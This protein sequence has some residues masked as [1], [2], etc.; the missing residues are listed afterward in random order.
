MLQA[1]SPGFEP[2]DLVKAQTYHGALHRINLEKQQQW[3]RGLR[4]K[5]TLKS[6][7]SPPWPPAA[8]GGSHSTELTVEGGGRSPGRRAGSGAPLIRQEKGDEVDDDAVGRS[9]TQQQLR[10]LLPPTT[11]RLEEKRCVVTSP[12]PP[13]KKKKGQPGSS[14]SLF[15]VLW[16]SGPGHHRPRSPI[17]FPAAR[18]RMRVSVSARDGG[19]GRGCLTGRQTRKDPGRGIKPVTFVLCLCPTLDQQT[20]LCVVCQSNHSLSRVLFF[21]FFN[22]TQ[23]KTNKKSKDI[24][25]TLN[26]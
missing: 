5:A 13:S 11:M 1:R 14:Y 21:V 22:T 10:K 25:L 18:A 20:L 15:C 26:K 16:W 17:C 2:G 6:T 8:T 19:W 9:R 12:R 23:L 24:N 7:S 4:S 3:R